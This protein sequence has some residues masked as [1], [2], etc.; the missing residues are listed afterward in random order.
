MPSQDKTLQ[1]HAAAKNPRKLPFSFLLVHKSHKSSLGSC[2][3]SFQTPTTSALH[4]L[5]STLWK[6]FSHKTLRSDVLLIISS[7]WVTRSRWIRS[8]AGNLLSLL[9]GQILKKLTSQLLS[10]L[11][12][13][14]G[15]AFPCRLISAIS[16]PSGHVWFVLWLTFLKKFNFRLLDLKAEKSKT[17]KFIARNETDSVRCWFAFIVTS[18][19]NVH[20]DFVRWTNP[21]S[22]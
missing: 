22:T 16:P 13:S 12:N 1:P 18:C 17:K 21:C 10:K 14:T 4:I 19:R 15:R 20:E 2:R 9:A 8:A 7:Q 3:V 11:R 6:H 5:F